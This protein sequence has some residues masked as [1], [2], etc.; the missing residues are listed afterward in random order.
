LKARAIPNDE[1][2]EEFN[3]IALEFLK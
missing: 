2:F 3:K 1:A